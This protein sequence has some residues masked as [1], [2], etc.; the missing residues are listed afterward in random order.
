MVLS[1]GRV[2]LDSP[3]LGKL[4]V[5]A[6][7]AKRSPKRLKYSAPRLSKVD[8]LVYVEVDPSAT[9]NWKLEPV[10]ELLNQGAVGVI[11]TDTMY[12]IVCHLKT[13]SAIERLRR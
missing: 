4:R 11:P 6:M 2:S 12:A 8:D 13:H 7:A 5:L 10:I 3:K 9:E 1:P